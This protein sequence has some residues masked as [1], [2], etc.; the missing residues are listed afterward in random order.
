ML[1]IGRG[2]LLAALD[3]NI[4]NNWVIQYPSQDKEEDIFRMFSSFYSKYL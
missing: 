2:K 3:S 1:V 4:M